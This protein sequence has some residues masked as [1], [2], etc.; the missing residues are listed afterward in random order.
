MS[1]VKGSF[2]KHMAKVQEQE[3]AEE[4]YRQ[5]RREYAGIG[6]LHPDRVFELSLPKPVSFEELEE[7]RNNN[8]ET[9]ENEDD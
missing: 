7:R 5:S 1:T 6:R 4:A 9:T 3:A 8:E 2:P